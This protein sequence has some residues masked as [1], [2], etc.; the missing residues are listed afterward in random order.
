[1]GKTTLL[2][3]GVGLTAQS[4]SSVSAPRPVRA[5]ALVKGAMVRAR[6]A[7]EYFIL[8]PFFWLSGLLVFFFL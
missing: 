3:K 5:A 6:A 2:E 4:G 1:M 8:V 7:M